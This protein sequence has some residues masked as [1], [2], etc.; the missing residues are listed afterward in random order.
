MCHIIHRVENDRQDQILTEEQY[1]LVY[2]TLF[3]G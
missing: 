1:E 2:T 3:L